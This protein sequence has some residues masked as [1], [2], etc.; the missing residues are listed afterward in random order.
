MI[1]FSLYIYIGISGIWFELKGSECLIYICINSM[2]TSICKEI[3]HTHTHNV[4]AQL[5]TDNSIMT[6]IMFT[7]LWLCMV[8]MDMWLIICNRNLIAVKFVCI[9]WH[10]VWRALHSILFYHLH[11]IWQFP[12]RFFFYSIEGV[13]SFI[14]IFSYIE[15]IFNFYSV[16]GHLACF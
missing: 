1:F 5:H 14:T 8:T 13:F 12:R 16:S 9:T 3:I 10:A 7:H 11:S 15:H 4:D 6:A 2:L